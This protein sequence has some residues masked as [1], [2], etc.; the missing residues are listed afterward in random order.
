MRQDSDSNRLVTL[1]TVQDHFAFSE[2]G[3]TL[4][5]DFAMPQGNGWR[6]FTFMVVVSSTGKEDRRF[7]ALATPIHFHTRDPSVVT[8]GWRLLITLP[9]ATKEDVPIGCTVFCEPKTIQ[10]LFDSH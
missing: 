2:A 5:P 9:M 6:E 7:R 8:R 1:L 4:A 3:L 10:R